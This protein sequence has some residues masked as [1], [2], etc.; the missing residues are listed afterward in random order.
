MG[1]RWLLRA[2]IAILAL[3]FSVP[4][5]AQR[6]TPQNTIVARVAAIDQA[7]AWNRYGAVQPH[8]MMF[9]LKRDLWVLDQATPDGARAPAA[10]EAL[11]A[12][13][14]TL[15]PGKRPRPLTLR[16]NKG[17]CLEIE[18]TNL[19]DKSRR[20][21][22]MTARPEH[23]VC[24]PR[25][26]NAAVGEEGCGEQPAERMA[27]LH[28][29]GLAP[30]AK[31]TAMAQHVGGNPSSL[32]PPGATT[33]YRLIA[34][35]EGTFF[36]YSPAA[37]IG[38]DGNGG[39]IHAGLFAAVTV[40]P[41]GSI[42]YRSQVT[43][44][45][46]GKAAS[47]TS[48]AGH[49]L[50]ASY[51]P[52]AMLA[53]RELIHSD[54]TAIIDLSRA[55]IS[56]EFR[57]LDSAGKPFPVCGDRRKPFREF[58]VIFH[59][60]SGAV[61]AF[62]EFDAPD[63][64]PVAERALARSLHGVRDGFAI[65]YGTAGAGAEVMA[66]RKKL[67]PVKAC[68]DC[69]MEEYFL[70]SWAVGDPAMVVDKPANM[71]AKGMPFDGL[72]AERVYFPEDPSNVYHSYLNDRVVIRNIHAGP[73]EHH[74][75]H[76]HA[77]QW[78]QVQAN[79]RAPYLDSQTIGPGGAYTYEIAYG[80]SGN[81]NRTAGDS[82]F[83]CHFYP[84]FAQGM[85]AL[86]R[87]HDVFEPGSKLDS[88]R[89]GESPFAPRRVAEGARALPDG[90]VARGTP[91]PALV[92]LPATAMA[93]VA[94][95]VRI[96]S[97]QVDPASIDPNRHP[98]YP[99]H[100]PARAGG[101]PPAPPLDIAHD[102]AGQPIDGGLKRHIITAGT[103]TPTAFPATLPPSLVKEYQTLTPRYLPEDGTPQEQ[104][105][106]KFHAQSHASFR[107]D[108]AAA[109]FV[110][111]GLK[112][113]PGA[114]FAEPCSDPN[115]PTRRFQIGVFQY[116][117]IL[118]KKGWHT[119]QARILALRDDIL[120]TMSGDRLPQPLF[121]R[122]NSG[123][124]VVV[125]HTNVVP[126]K[127][128]RDAFQLEVPT[129]I[130][131]QHIH[132]VKFDVQASDG[133]ANGFNYEDGTPAAQ[134]V[135]A[136]IVAI[137]RANGCTG[138][139]VRLA[140]DTRAATGSCPI[141]EPH[142]WFPRQTEW[143]GGQATIQR[144]YA[145]T[146]EAAELASGKT[147]D[148]TLETVFTHDHFGASN[149][150]QAGLYAGLI[151][152]PA[153]TRWFDALGRGGMTELG[154]GRRDGG[155][156]SWKAMVVGNRKEDNFREFALEFQDF[157][158][159][160][161]RKDQYARQSDG[162]SV[163][164]NGINAPHQVADANVGDYIGS[165]LPR[166]VKHEWLD[167]SGCPSGTIPCAPEIVSAD[168]IGV[169][170]VNY[171]SE[172]LPPRLWDG[173]QI[174]QAGGVAGDLGHVFRSIPRTDAD[175]NQAIDSYPLVKGVTRS[176]WPLPSPGMQPGDPFTP[177]LELVER[178]PMRI[179]L[180]AGA[181]EHEHSFT[182]NGLT[183][184]NA[185]HEPNSGY[186]SFV[187]TAL[188]EHFEF[189]GV[190]DIPSS[191]ATRETPA[192]FK[193]LDHLYR[194][195]ASIEDVWYGN[196]GIIRSY[197]EATRPTHLSTLADAARLADQPEQ[198]SVK[199]LETDIARTVAAGEEEIVAG[200]R[201][202]DPAYLQGF[203]ADVARLE[204]ELL[205]EAK[206]LG[207]AVQVGTF[208]GT[209]APLAAREET[210]RQ[211]R[212][213]STADAVAI[214]ARSEAPGLTRSAAVP[215][216]FR[217]A[218]RAAEAGGMAT[219]PITDDGYYQ[220]AVLEAQ[221][222][223][224]VETLHAVRLDAASYL[225]DRSRVPA[226]P[227]ERANFSSER[228]RTAAFATALT[229]VKAQ[230]AR[231]ATLRRQ[232]PRFVDH[233][234]PQSLPVCAPDAPTRYYWIAAVD[235]KTALTDGSLIYHRFKPGTTFA[236]PARNSNDSW[237]AAHDPTGLL[238][239]RVVDLDPDTGKLRP[240]RKIEPLILRARAGECISVL[241]SNDMTPSDMPSF[242]NLPNIAEGFN[243]NQLRTTERVGIHAQSLR[244]HVGTND[245]INV[246]GNAVQTVLPGQS[247]RYEWYAGVVDWQDRTK[248]KFQPVE[249][250]ALN[251]MPADPIK[252][253]GK[254][255]F[256]A[257]I[258]QPA[259]AVWGFDTTPSELFSNN[260][261][262][263]ATRASAVV[264]GETRPYRDFVLVGQDDANLR[265]AGTRSPR[266]GLL[267]PRIGT[268][269]VLN[270]ELISRIPSRTPRIQPRRLASTTIDE[271]VRRVAQCVGAADDSIKTMCE[272][273][274]EE[275]D[276]V[277][278]GHKAFNYRSEAGW[279]RRIHSAAMPRSVTILQR[280]HDLL[281]DSF[282]GINSRNQTPRFCA[283]PGDPVRMRVLFPNGHGRNHVIEVAGHSWDDQPF[284]KNSTELGTD[285]LSQHRGSQDV[286]GPGSH[287]NMLLAHGAGGSGK[288]EGDYAIRDTYSWGFDGGLWAV[289]RVNRQC[290]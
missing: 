255:L 149:H 2:V 79:A 281:S 70:S 218:A 266:S 206:S 157:H 215:A 277:D 138:S 259:D 211:D 120:P 197:R 113:A 136:R 71:Q 227:A 189:N 210:G 36:A 144:W 185:S 230:T 176:T 117:M 178:E 240:D 92:P 134:E 5:I 3:G 174:A 141:A 25:P 234:D 287:W 15:R 22:F 208:R 199:A 75:F 171:R 194:V 164:V 196:W 195:G 250:G 50:F 4:A 260:A 251:L 99:F 217:S 170:S 61:Q 85:W 102:T 186:R 222:E 44:A 247:R 39:A 224:A 93:P 48:S 87:V 32:V 103:T 231:F 46:M 77:H 123:N 152:E 191:L 283:L 12:G 91:I 131:G 160:F 107:A 16:V 135:V 43:E 203:I 179:R 162:S 207:I 60:E 175:L 221:Y 96:A 167:G 269:L 238:Y 252:Q 101:R 236:N 246:G 145:D 165:S 122:V 23:A 272:V 267:D 140:G 55:E 265:L 166:L 274:D 21:H 205:G 228:F 119:P 37:T 130:I 90:E 80:G 254:G 216:R 201:V 94:G 142:P 35:D 148:K 235:A 168:D 143:V 288:V 69:Q 110:T 147:F 285:P 180:L 156:T 284:V 7:W 53:G 58:T 20:N 42:W 86:W 52:F 184:R 249:F 114:P 29:T 273:A 67:G 132:L 105:A 150:Q 116:D 137:R 128:K 279:M 98:G 127:M 280:Q 28:V 226:I 62:K 163:Q 56:S 139:A 125:E 248:P 121:F 276:A 193:Q 133:G 245:G 51:A 14:V 54:L 286:V 237:K 229:N 223:E 73:K 34:E 84:H 181:H 13:K 49:P 258:I 151:V 106:M 81:R 24:P 213:F 27:G 188:S 88:L 108:G 219:P 72:P 115:A 161:T 11:S 256:G 66:N 18:F 271:P 1:S 68:V 261:I 124:C 74:V 242:A 244:K 158:M 100:V 47:G 111:N 262:P 177:L 239:V 155:P 243:I 146:Q 202:V 30:D 278:A 76:L 190:L 264:F 232:L 82:I 154:R 169:M 9:V 65:N 290:E 209:T 214:A 89:P 10:G 83:H 182:I 19:L 8:G 6:C 104:A 253:G 198:D 31:I 109:T 173:S 78:L 126:K 172:P 289:L 38:S 275:V 270:P 268:G 129:D 200:Y 204:A 26:G 33:T 241:L 40:E 233:D 64:A 263:L 220:Q 187:G 225:L 183:W 192:S 57:C 95:P 159:A 257:L 63:S 212:A 41:T 153:G 118:N 97:G 17:D 282:N 45:E 112:P 59:D